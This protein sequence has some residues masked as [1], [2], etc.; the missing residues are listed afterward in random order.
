MKIRTL[1][2]GY[3]LALALFLF[4]KRHPDASSTTEF[5]AVVDLT[6]AM[7]AHALAYK[8]AG[9]S[10]VSPDLLGT[11]IDAPAHFARD[12]WTVDQIPTDRLLAPL[13]VLDVSANIQ[14]HPDYQ[15]SVEDIARWERAHSQIPLGSVVIARTGWDSR[16]RS[17]KDY[18]NA[19]RKGT[20]HFPGYSPDAAKFLVEG[21]N[22]IGVGID[23]LSIDYGP[24]KDFP[25][26]QYTLAH[27]VY[28]LENVD[29]LD[30]APIA[31]GTVVVAPAK[32]ESGR[33]GP[34]RILALL[35]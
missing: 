22:A 24:S 33:S 20:M 27:S 35:H 25:V 16:W 2:I 5:H 19:D 18:R 17:V 9:K 34:V 21:R 7:D 12:L 29:N 15:V 14:S 11:R 6:H 23:T 10:V 32:L 13:V 30:R 26:R 1:I 4:A 31:G 3:V 8:P 28:Q